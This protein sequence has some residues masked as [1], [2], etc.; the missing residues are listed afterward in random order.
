MQARVERPSVISQPE[1]LFHFVRQIIDLK[2][3][4]FLRQQF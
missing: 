4:P 2:G 3:T 1:D